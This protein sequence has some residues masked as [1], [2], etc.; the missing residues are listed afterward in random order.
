MVSKALKR[1]VRMAIAMG[2]FLPLAETVRRS[3]QL[4]DLSRFFFWFDDYI[5]GGVLLL[6]ACFVIKKRA[7]ATAYLIAAWGFN[8]GALALSSLSQ[9]DYFLTGTSDPGVFSTSFVAVAKGLIFVYMVIGLQ[10]AIKA[11]ARL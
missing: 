9:L 3:N 2:I 10:Q 8:A 5:L 1:S 6:A 4:L 11:N 7:N